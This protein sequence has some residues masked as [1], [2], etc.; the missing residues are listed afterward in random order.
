MTSSIFRSEI[1]SASFM[2]ALGLEFGATA[3]V[4]NV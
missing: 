4:A 1:V 2:A 3:I